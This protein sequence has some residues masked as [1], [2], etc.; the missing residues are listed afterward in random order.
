M[1]VISI[2]ALDVYEL[3]DIG[4]LNELFSLKLWIV[5]FSTGVYCNSESPSSFRLVA[6]GRVFYLRI[7]QHSRHR[8]LSTK[9]RLL[10]QGN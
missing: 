6:D 8:H 2:D 3:I 1:N 4:G 10:R 7:L 5:I 9:Q